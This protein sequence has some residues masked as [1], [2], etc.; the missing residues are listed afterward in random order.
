M[1]ARALTIL[2]LIS[3]GIAVLWGL[4]LIGELEGWRWVDRFYFI[5]VSLS[6]VGYGDFVPTSTLTRYLTVPFLFGEFNFMLMLLS[7]TTVVINITKRTCWP[8][9][10]TSKVHPMQGDNSSAHNL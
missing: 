8:S 10:R 6:T 4:F 1:S 5:A 7:V 9:N 2:L 3:N